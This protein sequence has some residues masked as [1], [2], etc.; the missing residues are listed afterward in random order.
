MERAHSEAAGPT[1]GP[2]PEQ[3]PGLTPYSAVSCLQQPD[4][5][6]R[7]AIKTVQLDSDPDVP[8]MSTNATEHWRKRCIDKGALQRRG[9][10]DEHNASERAG[11]VFAVR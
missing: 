3:G 8:L 7:D 11:D 10:T 2:L 9:V 5:R 4:A 1:T 6:V